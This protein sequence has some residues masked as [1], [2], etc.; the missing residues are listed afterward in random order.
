MRYGRTRDDVRPGVVDLRRGAEALDMLLV[1]DAIEA[2][3]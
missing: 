1:D 3:V 2:S